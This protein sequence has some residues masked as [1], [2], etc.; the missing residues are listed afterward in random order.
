MMVGTL[1]QCPSP[2]PLHHDL[3]GLAPPATLHIEANIVE[4]NLAVL[5]D[6]ARQLAEAEDPRRWVGSITCPVACP[7]M[8]SGER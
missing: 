3:D 8:T 2:A 1:R 5:T 7:S 6:G 4:P